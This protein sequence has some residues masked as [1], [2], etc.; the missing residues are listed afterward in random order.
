MNIQRPNPA[1]LSITDA[2]ATRVREIVAG[3][4]KPVAGVRLGIKKGGCAGMTYTM[5]IAEGVNKGDDVVDLGEGVRVLVDPA[6]VLFLLG[7]EMDFTVDKLSARFVFRNPNETS[8]CGC[9]ESVTLAPAKS[10]S[11]ESRA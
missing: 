7:T 6:A 10:E 9:G 1:I 11:A 3:A 2:A 8:A 4:G 5:D